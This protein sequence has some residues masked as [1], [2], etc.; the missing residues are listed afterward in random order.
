MYGKLE[1]KELRMSGWKIENAVST[2][3]LFLLS[4]ESNGSLVP[5][6]KA[7]FYL[8]TPWPVPP[9]W[10]LRTER[11]CWMKNTFPLKVWVAAKKKN[12]MKSWCEDG[13]L[14]SL[15]W[16]N[17]ITLCVL[18]WMANRSTRDLLVTLPLEV[19][20]IKYNFINKVGGS[21]WSGN[22][23]WSRVGTFHKHDCTDDFICFKRHSRWWCCVFDLSGHLKNLLA[24][25]K[26]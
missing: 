5:S 24:L 4:L 12:Y 1:E 26:N 6:L 25:E 8:T 20:W 22:K 15:S 16:L 23:P 17:C 18:D 7:S 21:H 14:S 3:T 9:S 11:T 10:C 2:Y 19:M 13:C